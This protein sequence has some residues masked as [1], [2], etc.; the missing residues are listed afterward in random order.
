[1]GEVVRRVVFH[2]HAMNLTSFY[3]F[4][5]ITETP[6]KLNFSS[7]EFLLAEFDFPQD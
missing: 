5:I 6:T 7:V 1:M 2:D 3:V 4:Q